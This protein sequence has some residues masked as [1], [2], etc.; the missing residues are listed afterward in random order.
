MTLEGAIAHFGLA[1]IFL[2]AGTEGEA[3]AVAGGIVAHRQI[4]PLWQVTLAVYAGSLAAGQILFLV[5]RSARD[6]S[7]MRSLTAKPAYQ[8]VTRALERSPIRFILTYR[9]IFGVRTLTPLILGSS[10]LP[11]LRFATL[12]AV[13]AS[14]WTVV[15]TGLGYVFGK[16]VEHLFG[17]L[18]SMHHMIL[19]GVVVIIVL[20]IGLLV[21]RRY[22]AHRRDPAGHR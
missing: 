3:A 11:A 21:R 4:I 18:A 9:F 20:T 14:L 16:S 5:A 2:G 19:T 6:S 22:L 12:N 13:A 15:F 17:R 7:W 1:A 8:T 10:Q